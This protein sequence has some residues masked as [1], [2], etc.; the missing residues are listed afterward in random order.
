MTWDVVC[1]LYV[2]RFYDNTLRTNKKQYI[3]KENYEQYLGLLLTS[4]YNVKHDLILITTKMTFSF[5]HS[6]NP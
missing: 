1:H 4:S 2:V 6:N 5:F 3:Q